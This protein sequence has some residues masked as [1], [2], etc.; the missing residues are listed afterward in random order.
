VPGLNKTNSTAKIKLENKDSEKKIKPEDNVL[1]ENTNLETAA[2]KENEN[3]PN[4]KHDLDKEK[5]TIISD[6]GLNYDKNIEKKL[7]K[8]SKTHSNDIHISENRKN[9]LFNF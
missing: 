5:L 1:E 7:G 9:Y 4:E 8:Y 6:E 2:T 3:L